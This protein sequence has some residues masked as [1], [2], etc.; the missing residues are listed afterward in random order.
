MPDITFGF[1]G[2]SYTAI[3]PV[4][5]YERAVN[6]YCE[7]SESAGARTKMALIMRQGKKIH[8]Q[9]PEPFNACLES[10]NG[11]TFAAGSNLYEVTVAGAVTNL[12]SLGAT[13]V[14]PP[15]IRFNE[16]QAL[17][18]NNGSLFVLDLG[19]NVLTPV[20]M[21]QFNGPV[22]QIAFID[23]YFWAT[24]Q[25]SHTYQ[26]SNLEDGTTWDGLN[27]A[28]LSLA[29]D[30]IVSMRETNRRVY[31]A[32]GK[33]MIPFYNI[34][35]G[36]P[37]FAPVPDTLLEFGSGAAYAMSALENTLLWLDQTDRGFMV[38][39]ILNGSS[40]QRISTHAI[41]QKW[42]SYSVVSDAVSY[43]F[44]DNGHDFWV[45]FFPTAN[46]TW[47]FDISTGY[48]HERTAWN[49]VAGIEGADRAISHTFNFGMHLV[50]DWAS[51]NIY[52]MSSQ[53]YTDA[54]T[55]MR[56]VRRTPTVS[57]SNKFLYHKRLE[58]DVQTGLGP[59]PTLMDGNGQPR[60]P[61]LTL[62][63]SNDGGLTWSDDFV[64]DCGKA[65]E[66]STRV[67]RNRLGRARKR[68]Y[69]VVC[70]DPVPYVF[71]DAYLDVE[72]GVD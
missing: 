43:T 9:T 26:V 17:I 11:R 27:I 13:P 42:Q 70:T 66:Y 57:E 40:G 15:Q 4:I 18:K 41:E 47:V 19:T 46:A 3:S 33:K 32:S 10:V 67:I 61:Q 30:N 23:G 20:N 5:D 72:A 14:T 58:L 64:I 49:E 54:G 34:G 22:N 51:G 50:G 69:E 71:A 29:P 25:N 16:T 68:V 45:I 55:T 60:A 59:Q 28:T 24:I 31:L 62:R 56:L 6:L 2:P 36:F 7:K 63:W 39:R 48:W 44:Q 8:A 53:L 65:G 52:Q 1:C 38:A 35:G 21:A 37:P 12:G